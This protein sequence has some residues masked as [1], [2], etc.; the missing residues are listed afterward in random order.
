MPPLLRGR[1]QDFRINALSSLT[2]TEAS[3]AS[4][5]R[6][7]KRLTAFLFVVPLLVFILLTFVAPIASMLW[8]SVHHPTVAAL[9]PLT[10]SELQRWDGK[11]TP[12][13]QTLSVFAQELYSLAKERQSGKLA[14]EFNRASAGM[15][16]VVKPSARKLS[17]LQDA[18]LQQEG[19]DI[20][21]NCASCRRLSL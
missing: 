8:R 5:A 15:S 7:K 17:R 13:Q 16:S 12:D 6:N 19:A 10:L 14:E 20:L 21:L 2:S 3:Q 4:S 1:G 11:A 18:Q 9:I